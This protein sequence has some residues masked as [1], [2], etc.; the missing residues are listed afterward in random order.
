MRVIKHWHTLPRKFVDSMEIINP[1]GHSPEHL[2]L[3]GP[4]LGWEV[5][6]HDL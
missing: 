5:G 1:Y 3:V 6:L 2:A 4:A